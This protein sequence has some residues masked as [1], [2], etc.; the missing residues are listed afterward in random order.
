MSSKSMAFSSRNSLL[1]SARCARN[2]CL[3]IVKGG[4]CL[5]VRPD[6]YMYVCLYACMCM[7]VCV[8]VCVCMCIC[9]CE[10]K[11]VRIAQHHAGS[12]K[13]AVME[14]TCPRPASDRRL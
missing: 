7:Y 4:K 14:L 11:L 13:S 2:S 6:D 8:C 9:V 3:R 1:Y 12:Q 5:R 10:Y